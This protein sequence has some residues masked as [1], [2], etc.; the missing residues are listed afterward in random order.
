MLLVPD[1]NVPLSAWRNC[2]SGQPAGVEDHKARLSQGEGASN[3]KTQVQH[4]GT[5]EKVKV[6]ITLRDK[7]EVKGYIS[8]ID[9]DSF[10][11][12]DKENGK[13]STVAYENV[14]RVVS[15]VRGGGL[16]RVAKI[17]IWVG[18]GAAVAIGLGLITL[19]VT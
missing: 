8:Q 11:V 12:N 3:V 5:G 16:S 13:V 17:A 18:V 15:R 19:A 6:K 10:Q 7:T 1:V 4:R 14:Y 2:S 9:A